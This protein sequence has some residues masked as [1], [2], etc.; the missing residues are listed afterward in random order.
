MRGSVP[1]TAKTAGKKKAKSAKVWTG[2]KITSR[3]DLVKQCSLSLKVFVP[4][5]P[6]SILSTFAKMHT[7]RPKKKQYCEMCQLKSREVPEIRRWGVGWSRFPPPPRGMVRP[8]RT[9][10]MLGMGP[11]TRCVAD[12]PE[13]PEAS[14]LRTS[15][16]LE[17]GQGAQTA[18][19]M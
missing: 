1:H 9:N 6:R 12:P 7:H 18:K 2:L 10:P 3:S 14:V 15:G 11:A 5:A 13:L 19:T 8:P 4:P 17:G 16:G